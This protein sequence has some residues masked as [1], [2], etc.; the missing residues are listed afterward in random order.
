MIGRNVRVYQAVTLGAK[1][2]EVSGGGELLKSYPRH[3]IVEDDV[4]TY[5]VFGKSGPTRLAASW[6]SKPWPKTARS[7]P[8][9]ALARPAL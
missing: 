6:N 9:S 7:R 1:R 5:T 4:V 3:P 8:S 2:Y